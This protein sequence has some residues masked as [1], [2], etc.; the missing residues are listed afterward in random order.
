MK[1]YLKGFISFSLGTWFRAIISFFSTP[2]I[3]YLIVPEEFGRASMFALA[4]NI[5]LLFSL[6]GLDQSFVRYYYEKKE[7]GDIFWNCLLPS[8]SLGTIIS[9]FFVI[10]EKTLSIV[11]YGDYYKNIGLLFAISLLTGVLQRFNQLSIRMQKKGFL[12]SLIDIVSSLTNFGGT[13]FF[14][15]FFSKSF[16][17]IVFGQV[18]GNIVALIV[19]FF[20]DKE[21]R[22]FSKLSFEMLK[23]YLKY[24]IPFIPS[25]LLFWFFSS[26]DRISLRQFSNFTEIGLYSAAFKVVSVMQL[27][28]SGFTTFWVPVAYEKY[29]SK[30]DSKD[31]FEKANSL[32]SFILF[33]FGLFVLIFKDLIFMLFAKSYR[34]AS[35]VAPFLILYPIMYMIS[36]T[37]VLGI[38]FAK[39]TYWH[40]IIT[41]LSSFANFVGNTLLVPS[42]GAKGAA[43]STGLSYILFFALRTIIGQKYY[44]L[45]INM[46]KIYFSTLLIVI[47][48]TVGAFS[49]NQILYYVVCLLNLVIILLIY[50]NELRYI[51][52]KLKN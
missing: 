51:M 39:K 18:I 30:Y 43:I 21:Y 12:F 44:P 11:L 5:A 46:R 28:Q 38:N 50:K 35:Y 26:I 22:K 16:Y 37:T 41:A 23:E 40:I 6:M 47:V 9:I 45:N 14:A 1:Q 32:I 24:G 29:E 19:G 20:L 33:I 25:A 17:A 7:S 10:F 27:I 4:Y 49:R 36:E 48:A 2:V 34:E 8:I 42:L 52:E 13:V 31:F 15:L 3:S